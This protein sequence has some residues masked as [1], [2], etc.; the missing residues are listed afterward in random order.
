MEMARGFLFVMSISDGS[1][2]GALTTSDCDIGALGYEMT[3]LTERLG[4][5]L[6]PDLVDTLKNV[7]SPEHRKPTD[8]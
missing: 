2:I 8:E 7:L 5:V 3:L 1:L 6:T 4:E